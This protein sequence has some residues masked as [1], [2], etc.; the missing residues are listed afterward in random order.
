M[1]EAFINWWYTLGRPSTVEGVLVR[2]RSNV[3]ALQD[4]A[5]SC[6]DEIDNLED[7]IRNLKDARDLAMNEQESAEA[8]ADS[9]T[10]ITEYL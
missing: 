3:Q 2:C 9:L 4:I 6:E 8:L 10:D 1:W 5:L 7:R